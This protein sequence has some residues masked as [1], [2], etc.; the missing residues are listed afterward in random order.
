VRVALGATSDRISGMVIR[1]GLVL[2]AVGVGI[3][4][5]GSLAA[6]QVVSTLLYGVSAR[7]PLTL[8]GVVVALAIVST[9]A[10]WLPARRAARVDPLV[11]MR[12][13]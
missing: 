10:S 13:D 5:I 6:G 9:V 2:T 4:I 12:G 1:E 8:V 11:A 7:D 3:G